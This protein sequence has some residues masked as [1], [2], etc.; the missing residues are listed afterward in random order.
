[1]RSLN[2]WDHNFLHDYKQYNPGDILHKV[3]I[4]DARPAFPPFPGTDV[5]L[6]E[7]GECVLDLH[8]VPQPIDTWDRKAPPVPIGFIAD[9]GTP[10][11]EGFTIVIG[12]AGFVSPIFTG[13]FDIPSKSTKKPD[14]KGR[15]LL[16]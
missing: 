6:L 9:T 5:Y 8:N 13:P 10:D 2:F 15:R 12:N 3:P 7:T 4:I 14:P 11:A 1:M 16:F